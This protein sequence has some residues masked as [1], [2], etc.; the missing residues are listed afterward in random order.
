[1]VV[2][3]AREIVLHCVRRGH[4]R[5]GPQ[6]QWRTLVGNKLWVLSKGCI[7]GPA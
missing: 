3:I 1:M 7:G 5:Y 6:L 4:V 2:M